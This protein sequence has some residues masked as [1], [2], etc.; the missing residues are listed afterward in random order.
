MLQRSHRRE[1]RGR[2]LLPA[3]SG[4]RIRSVE[5]TLCVGCA[6]ERSKAIRRLCGG[7]LKLRPRRPASEL[8][9]PPAS[10]PHVLEPRPFAR[11]AS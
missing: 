1:C 10:T 4:A 3:S 5:R 6:A 11:V 7:A 9:T 8:A 2:A